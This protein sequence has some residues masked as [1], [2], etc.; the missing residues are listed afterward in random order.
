MGY[1]ETAY[2]LSLRI[3]DFTEREADPIEHFV[4]VV[5]N[6]AGGIA[7]F[8]ETAMRT[9]SLVDRMKAIELPDV[10]DVAGD[11]ENYLE[12]TERA[13]ELDAKIEQTDALIDELCMSY[14][15]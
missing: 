7:N 6:K 8:R 9:N 1:T 14:T 11:L 4:P 13:E 2:L 12:T 15:G 10:D 5:V 3:T